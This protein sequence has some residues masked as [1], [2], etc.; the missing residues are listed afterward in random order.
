[1]VSSYREDL[2]HINDAGFADFT[3]GASPGVLALL[4]REGVKSGLVVDLGCGSG[5]WAKTLDEAGY[6]VLGVDL[7]PAQIQLARKRA[8]NVRFETDSLL[9]VALP[10]CD[11]ITAIGEIVNYQFDPKHSR[12]ALSRLFRRVYKALRPGGVFIFDLAGPS[13][14]PDLVP[15]N[16]W[17]EGADWSLHVEVDGNPDSYWLTRKLVTFRR[18]AAGDYGRSEE[19]HRLR[20]LEP[21]EVAAELEAIGFQTREQ[22]NYGRFRLY[23][24]MHALIARKP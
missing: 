9:T 23:P 6:D 4:R 11:A 24:G 3:E 16:Y 1:M 20:L 17:K 18:G 7:S 2:A 13:R 5:H 15:A 14:V 22:Q 8:P 21:S 12:A 10:A 19:F